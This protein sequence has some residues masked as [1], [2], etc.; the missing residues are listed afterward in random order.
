MTDLYRRYSE[1]W[2]VW[3]DEKNTDKRY[4]LTTRQDGSIQV[5][6]GTSDDPRYI[7]TLVVKKEI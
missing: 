4:C 3:S 5:V 7:G 1:G 6:F 2:E